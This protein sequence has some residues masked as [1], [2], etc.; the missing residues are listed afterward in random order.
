V[1]QDP[2]RSGRLTAKLFADRFPAAINE[3][4]GP[5]FFT[6]YL[7]TLQQPQGSSET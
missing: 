7:P 4:M 1:L 5:H 3:V 2:H 6:R